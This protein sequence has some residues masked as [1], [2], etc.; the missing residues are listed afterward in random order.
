MMGCM[1]I[2]TSDDLRAAWKTLNRAR[3]DST[4]DPAKLAMMEAAFYAMPTHAVLQKD[5]TT[6]NVLFSAAGYKE[7]STDTKRWRDPTR[8]ATARIEYNKFF[9]DRYEEVVTLG[10]M[11]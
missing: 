5:G 10:R 9:R 2:D 1:G 11:R 4:F 3:N 6:R 7:I 8:G